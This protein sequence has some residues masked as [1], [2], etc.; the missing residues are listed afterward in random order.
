MDQ[1]NQLTSIIEILILEESDLN[2]MLNQTKNESL[3]LK[4]FIFDIFSHLVNESERVLINAME[5][6]NNTRQLLINITLTASLIHEV[7]EE[8]V[9]VNITSATNVH[10]QILSQSQVLQLLIEQ[11]DEA[12]K[13]QKQSITSFMTSASNLTNS[14]RNSFST[15]CDIIEQE[16]TTFLQLQGTQEYAN[17]VDVLFEDAKEKLT[18]AM[19]D[20]KMVS[21]VSD[22]MLNFSLNSYNEEELVLYNRVQYLQDSI[23]QVFRQASE[24]LHG[25]QL[26]QNNYSTVNIENEEIIRKLALLR[27]ASDQLVNQIRNVGML[28]NQSINELEDE[29]QRINQTCIKLNNYLQNVTVYMNELTSVLTSIATAE[30]TSVKVTQE[31]NE[32]ENVLETFRHNISNAISFLEAINDTIDEIIDVSNNNNLCIFNADLYR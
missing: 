29:I 12:I 9:K 21:N 20:V 25:V 11:L 30:D 18:R 10:N 32:Q 16:N 13:Q 27:N 26:I 15:I 28:I 17:L 8:S 4:K 2:W 24:I 14:N 19:N 3:Q 5:Q 31:A 1:I 22:F 6:S 23:D 7:L